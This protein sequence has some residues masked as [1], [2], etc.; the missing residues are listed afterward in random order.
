MSSFDIAYLTRGAST[1]CQDH[2]AAVDL[3]PAAVL[4]VAD[5][6]GGVAGGEHTSRLVVERLERHARMAY[7]VVD[8]M[9]WVTILSKL[10]AELSSARSNGETTAIVCAIDVH[11]NCGGA[12]IGDSAAWA[13]NSSQLLDLTAKQQRKPLLGSG[14]AVAVPFFHR[15][16]APW[17]ILAASDGLFAYA[18]RRRITQLML[19]SRD[20]REIA[21]DLVSA[22][23]LTSGALQD[24]VGLAIVRPQAPATSVAETVA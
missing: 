14:R 6:A 11:G 4:I 21:D 8:P 2:V 13:A 20:L 17:T 3:G 7:D 16:V 24:D 23:T 15:L 1:H 18:A 5:G 12:S 9:P 10:D 19:D 22:V